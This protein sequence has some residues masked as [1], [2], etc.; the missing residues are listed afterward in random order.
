[1]YN[2]VSYDAAYSGETLVW[3][4]PDI[5]YLT[6]DVVS[7][8]TLGFK[9]RATVDPTAYREIDYSVNGGEW[10]RIGAGGTGSTYPSAV[11]FDVVAGD[12]VRFKGI[13]GGYYGYCFTATAKFNLSGNIMS[14]CYGD[15]YVGQTTLSRDAAFSEL[16]SVNWGL[17]DASGLVLPAATLTPNCYNS[18]FKEC[19][20]MTRTPKEL[21]ATT[22]SIGCYGLMFNTCRHLTTAPTLP[23]PTLKEYSYDRMFVGCTNLESITCLAT[24]ISASSCTYK[25]L[26]GVSATGT[27]TKASSMTGWPTGVDGIPSGWTVVDA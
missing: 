4:R 5:N 25:W 13:N 27:F 26:D 19:E 24:N 3:K 9:C 7:G 18:M 10:Q 23:A 16:F 14:L 12:S 6:M 17:L 22:L 11:T 1:M 20:Y 21:P 15:N 2:G 8:G